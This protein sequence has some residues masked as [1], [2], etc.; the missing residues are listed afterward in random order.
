M[1]F[2]DAEP[3]QWCDANARSRPAIGTLRPSRHKQ[4]AAVERRFN[5]PPGW[6][7]P[8]LGWQP[9]SGWRP[10]PTWPVAPENWQF[11]VSFSQPPLAAAPL[12]KAPGGPSLAAKPD[13]FESTMAALSARTE[14]IAEA[15]RTRA[16]TEAA[17]HKQ[18]ADAH[19]P[20]KLR[21][22]GA[23]KRVV[24]Y[25]T[26]LQLPGRRIALS[27]ELRATADNQGNKQVVQGWVRRSTNDRREMLLQV[28][29]PG[30]NETVYWE[31]N[32]KALT[33]ALVRPAE[34][35]AMAAAI[36]Q[37]AGRVSSLR[38]AKA[39][40]LAEASH[41]LFMHLTEAD[42]YIDS[43]SAEYKSM[44]SR[45]QALIGER[46]TLMDECA[47]S[48]SVLKRCGK[49]VARAAKFIVA[50]QSAIALFEKRR[51]TIERQMESL[52]KF[53]EDAAG[54]TPDVSGKEG[55]SYDVPASSP[56]SASTAVNGNI[57]E[58][59]T[60]SR[61][62]SLLAELGRLRETGVLTDGEFDAKKA[63]LLSRL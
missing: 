4:A 59:R 27:A 6:P 19:Q 17:L 37:A 11:Y 38:E 60:Q 20:R 2:G 52:R 43:T 1:L 54:G 13:H 55:E 51:E 23:I 40:S 53:Q 24:L 56:T 50:L 21:A 47:D 61:T 26:Q 39:A 7:T 46:K 42:A 35:H 28:Q 30:G 3:T 58:E 15:A 57:F 10:D 31:R 62:I 25:D 36:N 22:I 18:I 8:P 9:P 63:E 49:E 32:D 34:V 45:L 29:W 41:K 44:V 33:G 12:D 16:A 14:A 5:P 48:R